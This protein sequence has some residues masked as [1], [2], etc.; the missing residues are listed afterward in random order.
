MGL[1][2]RATGFAAGL[3]RAA[4]TLG[5]C[6]LWAPGARSAPPLH[7]LVFFGD[8]LTAGYGLP[9]PET[10]SFPARFEAKI[11][12]AHLPWHVVNAGLSGETTAGGL[13]RID[14]VLRQPVDLVVIELGGNDGLRG[15][16]PDTTRANLQAIIDRV[17]AARPS[18]RIVLAG[19]RMPSS[20]GQD[21]VRAYEA[22]FSDLARTN[23]IV[24][25]PFL[26]D[27]VAGRPELNQADGIHPNPEGASRVA[28]LLWLQLRPFLG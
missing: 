25:V 16:A 11:E 28:D 18:A 8:S 4:L 24:L 23:A 22:V 19:M 5:A 10:Q 3:A 2:Y 6:L 21:F 9:D 1:T 27:G 26:L 20:M 15:T 14:W 7:T 12:A 17:R 13:R